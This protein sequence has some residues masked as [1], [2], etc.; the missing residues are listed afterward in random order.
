MPFMAFFFDMPISFSQ[1][2]GHNV[3]IGK[4]EFTISVLEKPKYKKIESATIKATLNKSNMICMDSLTCQLIYYFPTDPG[5]D[6]NISFK[7]PSFINTQRS[8]IEITKLI[9]DKWE[10]AIDNN[11]VKNNK[12][13]V[14]LEYFRISPQLIDFFESEELESGKINLK[15]EIQIEHCNL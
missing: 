6:Y 13:S 8:I 5:R 9:D 7:L 4:T 11:Y 15:F 12:K 10:A 14:I 1:E 3:S 2:N